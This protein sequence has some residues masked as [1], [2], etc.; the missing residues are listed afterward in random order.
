MAKR[1]QCPKCGAVVFD[2]LQREVWLETIAN[3]A[4]GA[5]CGPTALVMRENGDDEVTVLQVS[6]NE[7]QQ[8]LSVDFLDSGDDGI[9]QCTADDQPAHLGITGPGVTPLPTPAPA[10]GAKRVIDVG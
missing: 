8:V 9:A 3:T 6:C 7:C 2:V 10:R 4:D 5:G 1:K